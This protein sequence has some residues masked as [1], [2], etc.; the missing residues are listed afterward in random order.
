MLI[1][2]HIPKTGGS[3]LN[4][5]LDWNYDNKS[6][7]INRYAQIAPFLALSD[8]EKLQYKVLRGQIYYGIHQDIPEACQYISILR[9][10]YKRLVSQYFYLNVRKA[11]L[12]ERLSEMPFEEFLEREAFQAYMQL[13]LIAGGNEI[14]EALRRP[15]P[16]DA[17]EVAQANIEKH[18]PVLGL[19]DNYD[20]SLLLMKR[21]FGWQ[22]AFYSR[23]NVNKSS[24]KFEDLPKATQSLIEQACEP[25][26]AL[27][28]YAQKRL[29]MQIEAAGEDLARDLAALKA[30]NQRFSEFYRLSKP[31][32]HSKLWFFLKGIARRVIR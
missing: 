12:G 15:L 28:D 22:R 18:F 9:H 26:M 2:L 4:P 32:R 10:P 8:A 1:F 21:T 29:Q 30:A 6:F 27:Y 5:I 20:E 23:K 16:A 7:Q 19:I 3:T 14:N 31:I 17:L 11:T 25:E 24:P 13:N